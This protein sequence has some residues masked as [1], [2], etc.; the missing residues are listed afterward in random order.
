MSNGD[1]PLTGE[2][3]RRIDRCQKAL[4]HF[5]DWS[6]YLLVTTVAALGW[7][8]TQDLG[9]PPVVKIVCLGVL[10]FSVVLAILTLAI[11]PHVAE[12]ID[13]NTTSIYSVEAEVHPGPGISGRTRKVRLKPACWL[14]HELGISGEN[15]IGT[16]DLAAAC[17]GFV[18]GLIVGSNLIES[19]SYKNVLVVGA[20][21]LTRITDEQDRSTAIL[22]GDGAGAAVL[23]RSEKP[24]QGILYNEMGADG[25]RAKAI[26]GA[27][28]ASRRFFSR[29]P[30][31]HS[32]NSI[33][34]IFSICSRKGCMKSRPKRSKEE[35]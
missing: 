26:W 4:A 10:G 34:K 20:E 11:I 8:A 1:D 14:Q 17:S 3:L 9:G 5:K 25:S 27:S 23:S 21:T 24:G 31:R 32:M 33:Q 18:Y 30:S 7:V 15:G 29:A 6:N 19:G 13:A 35:I 12:R 28:L 16:F 22:F 2:E